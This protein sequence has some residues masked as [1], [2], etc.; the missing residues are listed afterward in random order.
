MTGAKHPQEAQI[1]HRL[2]RASLRAVHGV[3][4]QRRGC[5][6]G[7]AGVGD[8]VGGGEAAEPIADP[9]GVAGPHDDADAALHDGV[10][11]GEEVAGVVARVGEFVVGGVGAL[12]VGGLGADGAGDGGFEQVAGVGGG[13]VRV[14]ARFADV[15]DVKVVQGDPT[16]CWGGAEGAFDVA[17][18]GVV[19]VFAGRVGAGGGGAFREKGAAALCV[20]VGELG[21]LGFGDDGFVGVVVGEID[22][23]LLLDGGVV[24][25]VVDA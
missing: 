12:G 24:P 8:G 25:A 7:R 2:E 21:V 6:S 3:G 4:R 11:G 1:I 18:A 9:V 20:G 13:W 15:V 14:I 22:V 17:V 19:G 16:V 10:E 5:E 23:G